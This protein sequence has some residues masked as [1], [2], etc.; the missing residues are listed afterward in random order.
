MEKSELL[1]DS[2][3]E[4]QFKVEENG[5]IAIEELMTAVNYSHRCG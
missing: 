3:S 1:R 5:T 2:Y 4:S